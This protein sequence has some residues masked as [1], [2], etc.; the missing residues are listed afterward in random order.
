MI[1]DN[2]YRVP[3][4]GRVTQF[5]FYA[6]VTGTLNLMIWRPTGN[7]E[8]KLIANYPYAVSKAKGKYCGFS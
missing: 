5:E 7:S 1:C 6:E 2:A 4:C 8:Y 3:C